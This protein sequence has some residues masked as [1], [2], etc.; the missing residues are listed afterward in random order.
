[1]RTVTLID[2][3]SPFQ[4]GIEAFAASLLERRSF[5]FQPRR[6][7]RLFEALLRSM[8]AD[9]LDRASH[10]GAEMQA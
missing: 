9:D 1:M 8:A 6:D 5:P 4:V 2:D 10:G 3:R 7:L